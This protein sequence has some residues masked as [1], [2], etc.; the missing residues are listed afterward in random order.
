MTSFKIEFCVS[1][2]IFGINNPPASKASREV[3]NLADKKHS[4]FGVKEF[5]T[6]SGYTEWNSW[7]YLW[8]KVIHI[9]YWLNCRHSSHKYRYE[10][11]YI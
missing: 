11:F 7:G 3:T 4:H 2:K 10:Q 5:V 8:V 6:L 1:I 9:C